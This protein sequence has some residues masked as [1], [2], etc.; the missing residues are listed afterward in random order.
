M[1]PLS[2]ADG[3]GVMELPT[4][5]RWTQCKALKLAGAH[6]PVLS[7]TRRRYRRERAK[8]AADWYAHVPWCCKQQHRYKQALEIEWSECSY[9]GICTLAL[10]RGHDCAGGRSGSADGSAGQTLAQRVAAAAAGQQPPPPAPP[11]SPLHDFLNAQKPSLMPPVALWDG[12]RA[13][14]YDLARY[15]CREPDQLSPRVCLSGWLVVCLSVSLSLYLSV[16]LSLSLSLWLSLSLSLALSLSLSLSL[17]CV[18]C[19]RARARVCVCLTDC[20]ST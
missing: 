12:P 16:S 2:C 9:L 14:G 1:V 15:V 8:A 6:Q 20:L 10:K 11:P 18:C 17:V 19:V 3:R 7:A 4:A 5:A 13:Q